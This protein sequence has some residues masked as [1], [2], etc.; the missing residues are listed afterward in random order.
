M[1]SLSNILD[2]GIYDNATTQVSRQVI[3]ALKNNKKKF[4]ID[5]IIPTKKGRKKMRLNFNIIKSEDWV[6]DL[7][8]SIEGEYNPSEKVA[9]FDIEYNPKYITKSF[10]RLIGDLKNTI[11]HEIEHAAQ[12]FKERPKDIIQSFFNGKLPEDQTWEEYFTNPE[13]IPAFVRGLYKQAKTLKEP[14]DTT[15]DN[16]FTD[17]FMYDQQMSDREIE[18]VKKIWLKYA[19]KNLPAA[20]YS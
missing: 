5:V 19:R 20:K 11:R 13:E 12:M 7:P 18:R 14:L 15:I 9:T 4:A 17:Q 6:E 1:D 3:N 8:W 16:F 10:T 2:E